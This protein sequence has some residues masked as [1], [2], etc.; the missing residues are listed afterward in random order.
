MMHTTENLTKR[1]DEFEKRLDDTHAL[2][3]EK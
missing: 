1:L 3:E 2:L